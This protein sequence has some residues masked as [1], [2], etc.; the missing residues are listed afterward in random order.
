[1]A[2]DI[3]L[4]H[5]ILA[6]CARD[7]GH[8]AM[9]AELTSALNAF[10]H[11]ES[12]WER[13]VCSAEQHGVA[14]LLYK[15]IQELDTKVPKASRRLLQSLYL[16]NR[17][18]NRSRNKAVVEIVNAYRLEGIQVL[19]VKGIALCNFVYS[20]IGLRPMR[21]IDLLVKKNDLEKAEKILFDLGYTA[22][23]NHA[24]PHDYYHLVPLEKIIDGLP[25]GVELH[26]NLLPF[27][28]QYPLWPLEKSYRAA[29]KIEINGVT[30]RTLSLE[31]TLCYVYLHGFQAPLT[32]EPYRL[33]HVADI[34][35]LVE[36]YLTVV[37]WPQI[38]R[39]MSTLLN[40]ISRFHYLTPWSEDV[41]TE[42]GF[43]VR[44]QPWGVGRPFSG[45]PLQKLKTAKKSKLPVLA[46]NT[47]WPSQW[48]LQVYYG[49]L[50]GLAYWK[51]R[52]IDHP[53]MLW[54]WAKSYWYAYLKRR[55]TVV[56]SK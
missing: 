32:Y 42:L 12:S 30:A 14:S 28:P 10:P 4:V 15:H 13:M 6:L 40:S 9:Y 54:R 2:V 19:L 7:L 50:Q 31:D 51:A 56:Q 35:S 1:M 21:D 5:K 43:D 52:C 33:M 3:E 23:Q 53:R 24:I 29:R 25:V 45:W 11:Q 22:A 39:K 36:K 55:K 17:R 49:H 44:G 8:D 26:H 18:S 46:K 41:S 34:V 37:N 16:R 47:L 48:W 38:H 27:H 20:E